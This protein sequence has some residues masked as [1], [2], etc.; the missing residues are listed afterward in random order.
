MMIS[1]M[2][3]S[4]LGV[5]PIEGAILG[6]ASPVDAPELLVLQRCCW[7]DEAI[8]NDTLDIPAL[9]ETLE[10]VRAWL[11][12]WTSWCVRAAGRL[13]GAVRARQEGS[14]WEIGRLMVAPDL[15]GQGLG[16]WLLRLA[17]AR[18]PTDVDSITLFTGSQSARNIAMYERAGFRR[19][20]TP[21]PPGVVR[22]V[23][24]PGGTDR[25]R[26]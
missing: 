10:D 3:N 21:A 18:A 6:R 5:L 4:P 23:K 17:E 16:G 19:T 13:V 22:L 12:D 2:P 7:V 14:S 11:D 1:S 26:D 24:D 20:V 15:A 9:H 25:H 8:A